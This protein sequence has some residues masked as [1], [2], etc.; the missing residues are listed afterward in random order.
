M[1]GRAAE[2]GPAP[3]AGPLPYPQEQP[4]SAHRQLLQTFQGVRR[5]LSQQGS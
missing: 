2:L 5:D 4:A 3:H 1:A